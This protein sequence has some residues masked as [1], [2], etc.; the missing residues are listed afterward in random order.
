MAAMAAMALATLVIAID[1]T[2]A[3]RLLHRPA[4]T[5]VTVARVRTGPTQHDEGSER[6]LVHHRL[7]HTRGA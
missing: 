2:V 7:V 1:L 5:V 6:R 3:H 4:W